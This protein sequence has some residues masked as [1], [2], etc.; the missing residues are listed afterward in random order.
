MAGT[1]A[2]AAAMSPRRSALE[3][4]A[5][6]AAD[7]GRSSGF[8]AIIAMTRLRTGSGISSDSGGGCS[9]ICAIAMATCDSPVKGRRPAI[10]SY[11]TMPRE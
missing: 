4:R 3:A 11:A 7:A 10:D 1:A 9:L 8:L 2:A 6:T 5:T